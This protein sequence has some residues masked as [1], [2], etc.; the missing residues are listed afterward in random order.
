MSA[1]LQLH[2]SSL[3][4]FELVEANAGPALAL[5]C[6]QLRPP[7]RTNGSTVVEGN[8]QGSINLSFDELL[9]R[10]RAVRHVL[11]PLLDIACCNEET[12][13]VLLRM[14]RTPSL[15]VGLLSVLACGAAYVPIDPDHPLKHQRL[16]AVQ[17]HASVAL[18]SA[19]AESKAD[20]ES[21]VASSIRARDT[22]DKHKNSDNLGP[23]IR[24]IIR[25]DALGYVVAVVSRPLQPPQSIPSS[26]APSGLAYVMFTSGS[27]GL[28]KGVLVSKFILSYFF[29]NVSPTTLTHEYVYCAVG[30]CSWCQSGA[31]T[32]PGHAGFRVERRAL[33]CHHSCF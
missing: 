13:L 20:D 33:G 14:T 12:P 2:A 10:A 28:P 25:L 19:P 5:C 24:W 3:E 18:V 17:S 29:T 32:F 7:P 31:Q 26:G 16:I 1:P 30:G 8:F 22:D 9:A 4:L 23:S 6:P 21:A 15:V 11:A 27:T